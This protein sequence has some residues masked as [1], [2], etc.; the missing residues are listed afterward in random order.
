MYFDTFILPAEPTLPVGEWSARA[1]K[2]WPPY[3]GGRPIATGETV[4]VR[5]TRYGSALATVLEPVVAADDDVLVQRR[6]AAARIERIPKR[7]LERCY[8]R[9]GRPAILL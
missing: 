7:R 8:G 3:F 9:S 4:F 5:G 6:D 1:Q 2:A